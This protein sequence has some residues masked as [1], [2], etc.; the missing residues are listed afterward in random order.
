MAGDI[1]S[2]LKNEQYLKLCN[3]NEM[4]ER[5]GYYLSE[6]NVLHPFR[7]G[8]GRTQRLFIE[9]L[10]ENAGYEVDFSDVTAEEMIEASAESFMKEYDK[11]NALMRRI[12]NKVK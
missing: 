7:E 2:H 11:I 3:P 4:P 10:A 1:F 12:V 9:I 5:L 6:I 8:N